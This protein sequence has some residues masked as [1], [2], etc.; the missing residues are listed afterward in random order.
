MGNF[1][2]RK[3]WFS[4]KNQ[5]N[6]MKRLIISAAIILAAGPAF[7][8]G[9]H[10]VRGYVRRDGTYVAPHMQT[11][12]NNTRLD[13]WSTRGNVNPYTGVAGTKDPYPAPKLSSSN[14]K[15]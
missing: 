11:N 6:D 1:I 14:P 7:A 5:G 15:H 10:S 4:E 9:A 13:N 8:H 3:I 2:S 12:P